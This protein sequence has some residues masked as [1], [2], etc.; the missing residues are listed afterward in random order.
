MTAAAR[1]KANMERKTTPGHT[2]E[3]QEAHR[4]GYDAGH[5]DAAIKHLTGELQSIA[6]R[7]EALI[8]GL[9]EALEAG[10]PSVAAVLELSDTS[11]RIASAILDMNN[12]NAQISEAIHRLN[13]ALDPDD[14]LG[15]ELNAIKGALRVLKEAAA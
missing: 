12:S 15:N 6:D 13:R 2:E 1:K 14:R 4:E 5:R 8:Y 3:E 11:E 9:E 10:T 7:L